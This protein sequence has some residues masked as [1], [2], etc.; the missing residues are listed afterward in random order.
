V[1]ARR[2]A[3]RRDPTH[4]Q[5]MCAGSYSVQR[6]PFLLF[7]TL[8]S[9][10]EVR[11]VTVLGVEIRRQNRHRDPKSKAACSGRSE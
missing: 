11:H 9:G 2:Q 8:P 4:G 10:S 5:A 7:V 3:Q 1:G 6:T